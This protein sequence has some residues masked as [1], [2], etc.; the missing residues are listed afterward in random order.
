MNIVNHRAQS[1]DIHALMIRL[2]SLH[3]NDVAGVMSVAV[4]VK[5]QRIR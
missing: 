1:F 5:P 3:A 4:R 2:F